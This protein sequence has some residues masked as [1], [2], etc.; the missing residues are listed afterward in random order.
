MSSILAVRLALDASLGPRR[1]SAD[2]YI[3]VP[4]SSYDHHVTSEPQHV[5]ENQNSERSDTEH[6]DWRKHVYK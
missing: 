1:T 2:W 6:N 5:K 3:T 4:N